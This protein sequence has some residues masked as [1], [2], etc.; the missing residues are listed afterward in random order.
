MARRRHW[1]EL[2]RWTETYARHHREDDALFAQAHE[3]DAERRSAVGGGRASDLL[4]L[5]RVY[6][7]VRAPFLDRW[8]QNNWRLLRHH[9]RTYQAHSR[10]SALFASSNNAAEDHSGRAGGE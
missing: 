9:C 7:A 8:G 6:G 3:R 10:R 4:V 1:R 5:A 2:L